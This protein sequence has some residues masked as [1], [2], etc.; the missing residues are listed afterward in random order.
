MKKEIIKYGVIVAVLLAMAGAAAFW[1]WWPRSNDNSGAEPEVPVNVVLMRTEPAP[2]P[3]VVLFPAS[4]EAYKEVTVGAEI[5]GTIEWIGVE[6]G[7]NVSE[8]NLI[9]RVDTSMLKADLDAA[10]AAFDL[11]T[12]NFSRIETLYRENTVSAGNYLQSKTQLDV[13]RATLE[14]V[15]IRFEKGTITAPVA[16][17]LNRR[18]IERGEYI[19]AGDPVADIVQV[20][21]VKVAVDIPEKDISYV[22][23]GRPLAILSE[24]GSLGGG[25][26]PGLSDAYTALAERFLPEGYDYVTG[27]V[28]YRS[29]VADTGTLTY[30]VEVTVPNPDMAL[31][32]GRIVRA[33]VLRRIIEDA[34]SVPLNAVIPREGRIIAFVAESDRAKEV[35]VSIGI[36]D[37]RNI[38][39]TGGLQA[40]DMLVVEGQ[41]Q[42]RDGQ[43][44][45]VRD[46]VQ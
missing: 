40:G 38:Q 2:L 43:A 32:P 36:T 24:K 31:L 11:A 5:P 28:T 27:T 13:A 18:Y 45:A 41:R 20:D 9:A 46:A 35:E 33:A 17:I 29:V 44:I 30:R 15:R 34:I 42:L 19:K 14:A 1:F 21:R 22:T 4:V 12:T 16:G 25:K 6:E 10:Q 3:D 23:I 7:E 39:I 26:N 8:G 37:G